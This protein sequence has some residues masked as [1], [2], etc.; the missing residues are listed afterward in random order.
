MTEIPTASSIVKQEQLKMLG[1]ILR[2]PQE[3]YC[4]NVCFTKTDNRREFRGPTKR[5]PHRRNWLETVTE[6]AW[7]H[8][9]QSE[10][11]API[12]S[13][14]PPP[15]IQLSIAQR[16]LGH[17]GRHRQQAQQNRI[18]EEQRE[19]HRPPQPQPQQP[20]FFSPRYH[21]S[22]F[23][24]NPSIPYSILPLKLV[25]QYRTFWRNEVVRAPTRERV[26]PTAGE[27]DG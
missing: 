25:S 23:L 27:A 7:R 2:A 20:K 11:E 4:Q 6:E 1:H 18:Q 8:I 10:V 22:P 5:G 13:P 26:Q 21:T 24:N 3:D 15:P 16:G 12:N 19:Q 14:E 9:Q 17:G